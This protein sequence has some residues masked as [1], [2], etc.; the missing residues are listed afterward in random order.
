MASINLKPFSGIK[1]GRVILV[2]WH[3]G[4]LSPNIVDMFSAQG[5]CIA[6][7]PAPPGFIL[8]IPK[9]FSLYVAKIY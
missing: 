7:H 4:C 2:R 3:V 8:S 9:N 6:S 1:L 5:D